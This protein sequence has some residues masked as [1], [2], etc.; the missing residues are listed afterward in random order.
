MLVPGSS[1]SEIERLDSEMGVSE[2]IALSPP[3]Q[4]ALSTG[5]CHVL[6]AHRAKSRLQ[7]KQKASVVLPSMDRL[8]CCLS[9]FVLP[10]HL[11][12]ESCSPANSCLNPNKHHFSR[13]RALNWSW[14]VWGSPPLPEEKGSEHRACY[15]P[16]RHQERLVGLLDMSSACSGD[17]QGSDPNQG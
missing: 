17:K 5:V 6:S 14:W 11:Q 13:Q 4:H 12:I 2:W 15:R 3:W 10:F 7:Y 16:V 9:E 1:T 8:N